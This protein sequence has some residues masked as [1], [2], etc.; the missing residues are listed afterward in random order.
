MQSVLE[1]KNWSVEVQIVQHLTLTVSADNAVEAEAIVRGSN[2]RLTQIRVRPAKEDWG[3]LD[4]VRKGL[5]VSKGCFAKMLGVSPS[6]YSRWIKNSKV[7]GSW[8]G[9]S[10]GEIKKVLKK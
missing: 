3:K 2:H 6:S 4:G 1:M 9:V 8:D 7:P 10:I 5:G